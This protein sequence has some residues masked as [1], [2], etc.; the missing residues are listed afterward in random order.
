MHPFKSF[1]FALVVLA[2][3]TGAVLL[4]PN[5][6]WAKSLR[7]QFPLESLSTSQDD[8]FEENR[9][10]SLSLQQVSDITTDLDKSVSD[11]LS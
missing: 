5:A 9:E 8:S 10:D 6:Q 3:I 11:T 2:C 7:E 4:L 1:L